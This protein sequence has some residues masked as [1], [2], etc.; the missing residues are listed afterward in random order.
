MM[1]WTVEG[2]GENSELKSQVIP[3]SDDA[4]TDL[5]LSYQYGPVIHRF[6]VFS[7]YT[8]LVEYR[9]KMPPI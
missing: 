5:T 6:S 3:P 2:K 4:S 8:V 9:C 7:F 1:G